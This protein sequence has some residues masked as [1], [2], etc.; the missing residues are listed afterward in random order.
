MLFPRPGDLKCFSLGV[1]GDNRILQG[2]RTGCR[3]IADAAA[4]I[5]SHRDVQQFANRSM[6]VHINCQPRRGVDAEIATDGGV[7]DVECSVG[8]KA[9]RRCLLGPHWW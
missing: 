3:L 9:D 2:N 5:A 1:A 7:G 6:A 8:A 4:G